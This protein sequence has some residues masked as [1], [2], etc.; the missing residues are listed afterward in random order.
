RR[1]RNLFALAWRRRHGFW[2]RQA[3]GDGRSISR[4]QAD[5]SHHFRGLDRR[6]VRWPRNGIR[7]L[8]QAY[9]SL[10][11]SPDGCSPGTP[12]RLAF[13]PDGFALL[14]DAIRSLSGIHGDGRRVLRQF[15]LALV[16]EVLVKLLSNPIF[17]RA[18]FVL[19]CSSLAFLIGI[20]CMRKLRNS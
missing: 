11:A 1:R 14:P 18:A 3:D 2:R 4:S 10:H 20:V 17:L 12:A 6:F 7:C 19:F 5:R 15:I 13:G 16:R 8:S 9:A